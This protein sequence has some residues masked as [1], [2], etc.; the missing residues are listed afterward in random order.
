MKLRKDCI[1]KNIDFNQETTLTGKNIIKAIKDIKKKGYTLH[2]YYI[3]VESPDISKE[4]IKNRV[5]KGG[6]DIPTDIIEKKIYRNS[7]KYKRDI[8][9]SRLCK[10]L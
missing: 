8:A 9:F 1:E 10:D 4:R 3:G 2:L 6:H 7:R 5:A